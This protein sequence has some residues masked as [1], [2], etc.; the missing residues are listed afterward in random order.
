M[1][2]SLWHGLSV[3]QYWAL[4]DKWGQSY[5]NKDLQDV[6]RQRFSDRCASLEVPALSS[7]KSHQR[8]QKAPWIVPQMSCNPSWTGCGNCRF[9]SV[10]VGQGAPQNLWSVLAELTKI[11][12]L[13][14]LTQNPSHCLRRVLCHSAQLFTHES[15]F[16]YWWRETW[17]DHLYLVG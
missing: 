12:N 4:F 15:S 11:Q 10:I 7:Q 8:L 14:Y 3:C 2:T 6:V 5:N 1:L 17:T 13:I 9:L 16:K